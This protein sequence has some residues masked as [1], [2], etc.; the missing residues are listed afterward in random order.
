MPTVQKQFLSG[1]I[2]TPESI[3]VPKSSRDS[4]TA[5]K[6]D[7]NIYL[8]QDK[9]QAHSEY[10]TEILPIVIPKN[11]TKE[12]YNKW[13]RGLPPNSYIEVDLTK[14]MSF[15]CSLVP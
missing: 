6:T 2:G 9:S 12:Q 11:W 10:I 15:L 5:S 14:K 13:F 8:F 7:W 3:T 4:K 1:Y